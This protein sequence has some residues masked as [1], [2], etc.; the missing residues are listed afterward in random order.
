VLRSLNAE[1]NSNRLVQR[2]W[3]VY[4]VYRG[5]SDAFAPARAIL[6]PN[7]KTLGFVS[8]DDPETSLWRPFGS[9]RIL[10]V[11]TGETSADL[12]RRGIEYVLVGENFLTNHRGA[13]MEEWLRAVDGEDVAQISLHLRAGQAPQIWHLVRMIPTK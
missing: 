11:R 6:P 2:A 10:H 4:S 8:F 5:R 3:V 9:R 12:R 7:L 13:T 1:G